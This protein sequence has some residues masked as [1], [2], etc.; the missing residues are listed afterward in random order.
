M[1]AIDTCQR[2]CMITFVSENPKTDR[3]EAIYKYFAIVFY[4][5][6][7]TSYLFRL[8]FMD[9]EMKHIDWSIIYIK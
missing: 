7:H 3:L 5:N 6:N 2:S 1:N 9:D 8:L 4:G